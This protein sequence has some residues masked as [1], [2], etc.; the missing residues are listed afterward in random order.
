[1]RYLNR[2]YTNKQ[3]KGIEMAFNGTKK[4][5]PFLKKY[6]ISPVSEG[7]ETTIYLDVFADFYEIAD[8]LGLEVLDYYKGN[9]ERMSSPSLSVFL[10]KKD[11]PKDI[12]RDFDSEIFYLGYNLLNQIHNYLNNNYKLFPEDYKI[13]YQVKSEFGRTYDYL[14][15]I[16]FDIIK[17]IGKNE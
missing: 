7:F 8:Y 17:H 3:I 15:Y 5:Y 13:Y 10:K 11:E 2:N 1:M 4:K 16:S 12:E 14:I 6:V 9:E